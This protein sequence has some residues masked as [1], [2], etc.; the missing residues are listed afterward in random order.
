MTTFPD[1]RSFASTLPST[2]DV[3]SNPT[4]FAID[5]RPMWTDPRILDTWSHP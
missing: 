1:L 4:A 2:G 3:V 5:E